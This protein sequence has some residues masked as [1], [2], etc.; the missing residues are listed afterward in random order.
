MKK[1]EF[2]G[3]LRLFKSWKILIKLFSDFLV[4]VLIKI[5]LLHYLIINLIGKIFYN[6]LKI[7]PCDFLSIE[8]F[9]SYF[10]PFKK[11]FILDQN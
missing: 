10:S 6:H 5:N 8:Y 3:T 7:I 4:D 2:V 1:G 9:F 11:A